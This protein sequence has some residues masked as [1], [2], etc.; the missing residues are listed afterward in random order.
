VGTYCVPCA[1][2]VTRASAWR[3][4]LLPLAAGAV[5][6]VYLAGIMQ[7]VHGNFLFLDDQGYDRVGWELAQAWHMNAFLPPETAAVT[8][9]WLYYAFTAAVYFVIGR[10]WFVV[11]VIVALLSSLSVPAAASIGISLDGRRLGVRA[12]WL[13][14]LY[15]SAVFWGSTGLKDGPLAA[16]LLAVAAIALRPL[17]LRRLAAAAALLTLAFLCR[18]VEGVIGAAMLVVP[19]ASLLRSRY[20]GPGPRLRPGQR[21]LVLA[22]GI[23][24][25]GVLLAWQAARYLPALT[26]SLAG[27]TQ[28]SLGTGPVTLN[29]TP[30]PSE[31]AHAVLSPLRWFGASTSP[32]YIPGMLVWTVMLPTTALGCWLLLR[33]GAP[34]ARGVIVSGLGFMYLY[35]CV[36]QGPGFSRQ[37]FTV[38]V[39]FLVAALYAFG[40]YPRRAGAWTA[41]AACAVAPAQLV[42]AHVIPVRAVLALAVT[43]GGVAWLAARRARVSQHRVTTRASTRRFV[44]SPAISTASRGDSVS[45]EAPSIVPDDEVSV[46]LL[47]ERPDLGAR[48][49]RRPGHPFDRAVRG[50]DRPDHPLA[51]VRPQQ[52]GQAPGGGRR[53]AGAH[54]RGASPAARRR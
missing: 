9:S 36:F 44:P 3:I 33:S 19:T 34:A 5:V 15:P 29:Y 10:H 37:R 2:P 38:E 27:E 23:P 14:A 42:Q 48:R 28:L 16:L 4:A 12:A 24:A 31:F 26:A 25:A 53:R 54:R 32:G 49:D 43:A 13:A 20:G 1:E 45:H 18:P 50:T 40:R 7:V 39:L 6:R 8:A 46:T 11:K 21:L 30:P 47:A 41:L 51:R 22:A 52:A 17:T 35:T